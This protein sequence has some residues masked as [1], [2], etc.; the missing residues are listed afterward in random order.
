[1]TTVDLYAAIAGLQRL[2]EIFDLRRRQLAA[3]VGLS[4]GQWRLL[5]EIAGDDFMPS[6]FARRRDCSAAAVSRTL[7]QLQD[8]GLVRAAISSA[9]ARQRCYALKPKGRRV[10]AQLREGREQAL[11]AVWGDLPPGEIERF[12]RF[13]ADLADRLEAYAERAESDVR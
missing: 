7:K 1:V 13:S 2:A 3:A 5:E 12:G 9:D 4:D 6:L 10:L 11:A 8:K